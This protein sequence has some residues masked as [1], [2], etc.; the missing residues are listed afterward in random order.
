MSAVGPRAPSFASS[1]LVSAFA[2]RVHC[3]SAAAVSVPR[4]ANGER[5][6]AHGRTGSLSV[7]FVTAAL[8][9]DALPRALSAF[10]RDHPRVRVELRNATSAQQLE[11]VR[12][13][14]LDVAL[15]HV[16][17]PEDG[18]LTQEVSREHVCLAVP[19][20]H[21]LAGATRIRPEDL[22]DA[23]WIMLARDVAPSLS[24]GLRAFAAE[25]G[26]RFGIVCEVSNPGAVVRLV[27]CGLG[28]A[29]LPESAR[30]VAPRGVVFRDPPWAIAPT[31]LFLVSRVRPRLPIVSALVALVVAPTP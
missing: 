31:S 15:V 27:E 23:R 30:R 9:S 14:Y 17:R 7:G 12:A 2:P 22:D 16:A 10:A 26:L 20:R 18:L 1:R 19:R 13:G 29:L 8:W 3:A 6:R 21:A 11:A 25:R 4:V 24:E 5:D 28:I